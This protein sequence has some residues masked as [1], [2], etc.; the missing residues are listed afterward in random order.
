MAWATE[1]SVAVM[2]LI[3][4]VAIPATLYPHQG[5]PLP[6]WP[7]SITINALLSVYS[8]V[9]KTCIA[10]LVTSCV[11]QLQWSWYFQPRP[12]QDI[13]LFRD[14]AG[15]AFGSISWLWKYPVQ[16][17]LLTLAAAVT[18][19]SI[20]VDP[21]MQ[22]LVQ[23]V[24]CNAILPGN[25]SASVP[26][27]NY[28]QHE[29]L[30]SSLEQAILAG[31]FTLQ[32]LTDFDCSTG[33]CTFSNTYSTVGFCSQC[34]DKS[35]DIV[36][37]ENCLVNL[38]DT[39]GS[40]T[41]APGPCN[42]TGEDEL[43]GL[44]NI[45]TT[46]TPF[47]LDFYYQS[48]NI[49]DPVGRSP[50][51]FSMQGREQY[52]QVKSFNISQQVL[53]GEKFGA[54][55]GYSDSAIFRTDPA[56]GLATLSGC[57]DPATNDTWRCKGYGAAECSLQPCIK[58]YSCSIEAGIVNENIVDQ[59]S[60]DQLWGFGE[61]GTVSGGIDVDEELFGLVD[62][63]CISDSDRQSLALAGY[64]TDQMSRWLPYNITFDPSTAIINSSSPFPQ[65][66]LAE[67]CLY[68]VDTF[69][70]LHL[71]EDILSPL[72]VGPVTRSLDEDASTAFAYTF[73]GTQQLLQLYDSGNVSM[74]A[75]N[76]TFVNLAQ[77]LTLWTRQ[78]G[79]PNYSRRAE[80]AVLHY[81]VCVQVY[82]AWISLPAALAGLAL[83][84]FVLTVII[85]ARQR[86]PLWRDSALPT[87]LYGPAGRDWV[88]EDLIQSKT[89]G[90]ATIHDGSVNSMKVYANAISVK[91][92]PRDGHYELR[93][94]ARP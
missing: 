22:Q 15:G 30:P 44:W 31:L 70:L 94:V 66:L 16:Q 10:G 14:L 11:S 51:V 8:M 5:Q 88:D 23:P 27:T 71:W 61:P 50:Q 86:A 87:L 92:V 64:P 54:I 83:V 72:L 46:A 57:D 17:P 58:T 6:Q 38:F 84:L 33:N 82:W 9:L 68:I 19:I 28:L 78:N 1:T 2:L 21:F 73:Q 13:A 18:I 90:K 37:D 85:T 75:I 74:D 32:N 35:A 45:T 62:M 12:L 79:A 41:T 26:R 34:T 81:A 53:L 25:V 65:S 4:I 60:L 29:D 49:T 20:A 63:D 80:G 52:E 43:T 3:S 69:F 59:T 47:E 36:I 39:N 24:N 48:M 56:D 76:S 77:A 91:L 40:V 67:N 55:L 7:F 93:Q 89:Q 42:A